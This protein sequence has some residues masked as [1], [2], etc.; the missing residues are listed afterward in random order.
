V[1]TRYEKRRGDTWEERLDQVRAMMEESMRIRIPNPQDIVCNVICNG[2]GRVVA[3]TID[4]PPKSWHLGAFG[5]DDF[6][7]ECRH[8]I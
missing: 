8:K 3:G 5:E 1:S 6:C 4:H 2:C 7:F